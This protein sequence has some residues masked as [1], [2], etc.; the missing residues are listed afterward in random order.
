MSKH[1]HET[2]PQHADAS[3]DPDAEAA[4]L[5]RRQEREGWMLLTAI[6]VGGGLVV[7]LAALFV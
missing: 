2:L 3:A 6:F 7:V 1:P 5:A 4:R